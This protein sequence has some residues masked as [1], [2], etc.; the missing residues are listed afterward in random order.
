MPRVYRDQIDRPVY[1]RS[2]AESAAPD[3]ETPPSAFLLEP[4][5]CTVAIIFDVY[6]ISL[7]R[8][9]ID[10]SRSPSP[11]SCPLAFAVLPRSLFSRIRCVTKL[12]RCPEA[13]ISMPNVATRLN[14]VRNSSALPPLVLRLAACPPPLPPLSPAVI[15]DQRAGCFPRER[16]TIRVTSSRYP[17]R[18]AR[19]RWKIR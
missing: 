8:S 1:S 5:A 4:I 15:L 6:I 9:L 11:P 16:K 19:S 14:V 18:G 12:S 17:D 3:K 13:S 7:G 10:S 2:L